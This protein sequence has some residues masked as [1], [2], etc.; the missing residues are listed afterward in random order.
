MVALVS[1][2]RT[3]PPIY[4]PERT[5]KNTTEIYANPNKIALEY[6]YYIHY[7][8]IYSSFLHSQMRFRVSL[9]LQI[10]LNWVLNP[11]RQDGSALNR[12]E[13]LN[14]AVSIETELTT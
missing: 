8:H 7:E 3:K 2:L 5:L 9:E 1:K 6:I 11:S 4:D 12:K 10:P 13:R 14:G